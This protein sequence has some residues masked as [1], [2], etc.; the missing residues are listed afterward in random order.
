MRGQAGPGGRQ[1]P[2]DQGE[3]AYRVSGK[4][5]GSSGGR[6]DSPLIF[7]REDMSAIYAYEARRAFA[8]CIAGGEARV[9]LAEAALHIAAEDDAL[10]SHSSVKFPVASY[11]GRVVKMV[12]EL[13][14]LRL[15]D[16]PA[17]GCAPADVLEVVDKYL[18][19]EQRL[20]IPASGRSN[21]P[22]SASVAH[23]GVWE[24]ARHSYLNEA[25]TRRVASPACLAILYAEI[26]QRL[27]EQVTGS[28][29]HHSQTS[30]SSQPSPPHPHYL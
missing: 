16:L 25:L 5:A 30:D 1:V 26:M 19:E 18:F 21:L 7:K 23:P 20:R 27:L 8:Q 29:L 10:V 12:D 13:A 28:P 15:R 24:E 6:S 9:N 22:S 14:R 2:V 17:G 4:P 3:A 11:L